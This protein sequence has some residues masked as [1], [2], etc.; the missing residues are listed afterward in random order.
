VWVSSSRDLEDFERS[1]DEMD[2]VFDM[3][4]AREALASTD[5]LHHFESLDRRGCRPHGLEAARGSND[6]FER[7]VVCLDDVV[8]VLAHAM[9]CFA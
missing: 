6:S 9:F 7:S 3:Q 5:H 8:E 4:L 2:L 1:V